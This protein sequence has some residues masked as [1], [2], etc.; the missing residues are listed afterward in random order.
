MFR[1]LASGLI[2]SSIV[3]AASAAP[4]VFTFSAS[5]LAEVGGNVPTGNDDGLVARLTIQDSDVDGRVLFFFENLSP[6]STNQFISRLD[7]NVDPFPTT[8]QG[9]G[10]STGSDVAL[11]D[12]EWDLNGINGIEG[13]RF[14]VM[15]D[16]PN[17]GAARLSPGRTSDFFLTGSGLRASH[18]NALSTVNNKS[19]MIHLQSLPN[20]GS[21]K[22]YAQVTVI[23]GPAALV[24]FALGA[25]G[26]ARRRRRG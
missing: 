22:L 8:G 21:T 4:L 10:T 1:I 17:G 15:L 11:S 12:F 7:L 9:G 5:D 16:F 26:V 3:A 18:F 6:T 23:P 19:A 14:D 13:E 20:G 24:P 25:V 2:F